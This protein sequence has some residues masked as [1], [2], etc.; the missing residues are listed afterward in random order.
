V[1][2]N[3]VVDAA[4]YLRFSRG[5]SS[6]VDWICDQMPKYSRAFSRFWS[7]V[8]RSVTRVTIL[9]TIVC[10]IKPEWLARYGIA[11]AVVSIAAMSSVFLTMQAGGALQSALHLRGRASHLISE[12]SQAAHFLAFIYVAFT[13]VVI[14]TFAAQRISGGMATGLAILDRALHPP[15]VFTG[16]RFVLVLLSLGAAVMVFRVGDLGAKAVW[17][18]RLHPAHSS[19]LPSPRIEAVLALN[20]A[21]ARSPAAPVSRTIPANKRRSARSSGPTCSKS[22]CSVAGPQV[23]SAQRANCVPRQLG[24]SPDVGARSTGGAA[25]GESDSSR[26]SGARPFCGPRTPENDPGETDPLRLDG[27]VSFQRRVR[28]VRNPCLHGIPGRVSGQTPEPPLDQTGAP[29]S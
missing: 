27:Q 9:A 13:A 11:L 17:Q 28:A 19:R 1:L 18:G 26:A 25:G 10:L 7:Q 16:L 4:N 12:H 21:H 20:R 23:A 15:G 5:S 2:P 22:T 29:S 14:L 3:E 6:A 24:C 8:S